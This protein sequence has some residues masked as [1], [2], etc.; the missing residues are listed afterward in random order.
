MVCHPEVSSQS[1]SFP[2]E[3]NQEMV[4]NLQE[5][6]RLAEEEVQDFVPM[7]TLEG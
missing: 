4:K 1:S 6:L 3:A 7:T 5:S 2:Q